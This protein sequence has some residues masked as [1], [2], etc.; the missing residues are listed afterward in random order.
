MWNE[1]GI[2]SERRSSG[3]PALLDKRLNMPAHQLAERAEIFYKLPLPQKLLDS[4]KTFDLDGEL[5]HSLNSST[6]CSPI[7]N[8]WLRKG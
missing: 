2:T 1:D 5:L 4:T 3:Q 8:R 6:S 7:K